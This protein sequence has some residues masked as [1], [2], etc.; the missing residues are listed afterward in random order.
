MPAGPT[1]WPLV[2]GAALPTAQLRVAVPP[3]VPWVRSQVGDR[4]P[5]RHRRCD[6]IT[7]AIPVLLVPA[8][9][10]ELPGPVTDLLSAAFDQNDVFCSSVQAPPGCN[11]PGFIVAVGGAEVLPSSLVA[12]AARLVAGGS[13]SSGASAPPAI[14]SPFLT[15][16]DLSPVYATAPA[17]AA[18]CVARNGYIGSR[19]LVLQAGDT[20]TEV[21]GETDVMLSGRFVRDADGIVRTPGIGAPACVGVS[22]DP[23]SV[24]RAAGAGIA[25]RVGTTAPFS[26]RSIDRLTQTA[27]IVGDRPATASGASTSDDASD[28]GTSTF[29]YITSSPDSGLVSRDRAASITSASLTFTLTR[30]IDQVGATGV[31]VYAATFTITTSNGT[32][33]GSSEGEAVLEGSVWHLRGQTDIT[34]G[35]WNAQSGLGGFRA[36]LDI[37]PTGDLDDDM[38]SWRIDA[39]LTE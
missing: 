39:V 16:L 24:I 17:T 4:R 6:P 33:T 27:P 23:P 30:G 32:V 19:W 38:V 26:T 12:S 3:Y 2:R 10:I 15:S 36:D 1:P 22:S 7:T 11:E 28:G 29:T 18:V 25:G 14:A 13:P 20:S 34:G 35:T 37:G 8:G 9:A 31:D 5:L 21:I